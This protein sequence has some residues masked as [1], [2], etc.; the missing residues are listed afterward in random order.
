MKVDQ[1]E[2]KALGVA[3][4]SSVIHRMRMSKNVIFGSQF[5]NDLTDL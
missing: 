5:I 2:A 1:E 3:L 4:D